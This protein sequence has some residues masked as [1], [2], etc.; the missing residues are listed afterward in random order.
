[1]RKVVGLARLGEHRGQ[2]IVDGLVVEHAGGDG[3]A[4]GGERLERATGQRPREV[5]PRR[6]GEQRRHQAR[7]L[8]VLAEGRPHEQLRRERALAAAVL[9]EQAV[10]LVD[11][12][13]V[14][15]RGGEEAAC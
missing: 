15:K 8:P 7:A 9:D 5:A 12:D 14:G 1:L 10:D 3:A 6:A 2:V 4:E 13:A 11:R